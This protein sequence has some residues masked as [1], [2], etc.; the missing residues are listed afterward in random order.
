MLNTAGEAR[1]HDVLWL[2]I[3][4][5]M[6]DGWQGRWSSQNRPN[7]LLEE[8]HMKH[9][10]QLGTRRQLEAN[11]DRVDELDYAVRPVVSGL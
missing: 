7:E 11:D 5:A 6:V 3:D 8:S 10:M 4:G 9:I 2:G 1:A